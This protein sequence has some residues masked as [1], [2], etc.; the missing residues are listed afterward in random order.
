MTSGKKLEMKSRAKIILNNIVIKM[1]IRMA[2]V[3]NFE[4]HIKAGK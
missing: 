3:T 1:K 2:L 4:F